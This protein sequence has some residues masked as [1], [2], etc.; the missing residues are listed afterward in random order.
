MTIFRSDSVSDSM[1]AALKAFGWEVG[2][3]FVE[4][5]YTD[6]WVFNLANAVEK[7]S[8]EVERLQHQVAYPSGQGVSQPPVAR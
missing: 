2:P 5:Y 1:T 4:R 7:L 8:A 6:P 3:A